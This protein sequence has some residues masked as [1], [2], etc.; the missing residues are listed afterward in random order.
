MLGYCESSVSDRKKRLYLVACC[1]SIWRHLSHETSRRAVQVAES[2]ADG[3]ASAAELLRAHNDAMEISTPLWRWVFRHP[4]APA[5]SMA[6]VMRTASAAV[7]ASNAASPQWHFNGGPNAAWACG[8][9]DGPACRAELERQ[10]CVLR[11]LV[12]NPFRPVTLN[13]SWLTSTVSTLAAGIYAERAFDHFPILA[14]ALQDAGCGNADI[15]DHC[16]GGGVHAR[17]CWV[18]DLL[19]GK[20]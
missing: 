9:A 2:F 3:S 1:R 14:D 15:L 20:E 7:A 12:G 16:R 10:A 19:L 13:P 18:V 6:M 8:Q 4:H 11:C 17:G 5:H